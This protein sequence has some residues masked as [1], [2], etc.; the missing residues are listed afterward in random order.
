MA[1]GA[2]TESLILARL[3]TQGVKYQAGWILGTAATVKVFID[4]FI[5][6]WAFMLG[7]IWTNQI[8]GRR[9]GDLARADLGEIPEIRS[10][11]LGHLRCVA[12]SCSP[13]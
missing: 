5:G 9:Q 1:S 3:Q 6:I 4:I 7:Y 12:L 11:I 2:I 8:N 13:G 10:G